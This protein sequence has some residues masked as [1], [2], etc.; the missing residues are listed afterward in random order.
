MGELRLVDKEGTPMIKDVMVRLD[1]T[2][3][4]ETRLAAAEIFPACSTGTSS[5]CFSMSCP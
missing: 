5:G 2:A 4:D 1:G 3:A